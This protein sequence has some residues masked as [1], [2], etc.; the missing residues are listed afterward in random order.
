M[1]YKNINKNKINNSAQ[2]EYEKLIINNLLPNQI[3]DYNLK[4]LEHEEFPQQI[5]DFAF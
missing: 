3:D 4:V 1:Q 2:I 5:S